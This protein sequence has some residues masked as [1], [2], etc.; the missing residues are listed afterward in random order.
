MPSAAPEDAPPGGARPDEEHAAPAASRAR[1][2]SDSASGNG[3][4]PADASAPGGALPDRFADEAMRRLE[5]KIRTIWT[6]KLGATLLL[7]VGVVFFYE[8]V[9]WMSAKTGAVAAWRFWMSGGL[10]ALSVAACVAVPRLRYRY[11]RYA[12]RAEEL[13]LE[14]GVLNRVRTV[15]PLRRIQHLDVSQDLFEREFDLGTLVVHTAGGRSSNVAV[16]GLRYQTAEQMR[17]DVK[18]YVLAE[19]AHS[20]GV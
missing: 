7:L 15:V 16:P 13:Y 20:N 11:W 18:Q 5:P 12:L 19:P 6:L 4:P 14:R 2:T 9:R 1:S 3:Q 10:A 17:D 8:I